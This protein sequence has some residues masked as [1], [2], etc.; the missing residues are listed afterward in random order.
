[1]KSGEWDE[2]EE[3][4]EELRGERQMVREMRKGSGVKE[5][6][7]GRACGDLIRAGRKRTDVESDGAPRGVQHQRFSRSSLICHFICRDCTA[8]NV[9]LSYQKRTNHPWEEGREGDMG[10]KTKKKDLFFLNNRFAAAAGLFTHLFIN[11]YAS[12]RGERT[13]ERFVC[14]LSKSRT[15]QPW[16]DTHTHVGVTSAADR[17]CHTALSAGAACHCYSQRGPESITPPLGR[18]RTGSSLFKRPTDPHLL[19][20]VFSLCVCVG[21]WDERKRAR[22]I[23]TVWVG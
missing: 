18:S 22:V 19:S 15:F 7:R 9:L 5:R 8:K 16:H 14:I 4:E 2:E 11:H 10:G 17:P 1:M 6:G 23:L 3:G 20:S 12:Q 13:C 21:A